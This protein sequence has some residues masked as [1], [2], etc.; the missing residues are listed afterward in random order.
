M[1]EINDTIKEEAIE[2]I[3]S[4]FASLSDSGKFNNVEFEQIQV[5]IAAGATKYSVNHT[6]AFRHARIIGIALNITDESVLEG[7]TMSMTIDSKEIF[8]EGTE[9]KLLFASTAVA[10]NQKFY[11]YVD[12]DINQST[13]NVTFTSNAF[14]S[15]YQA[16]FYLMCVNKL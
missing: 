11:T 13:V 7:T 5:N 15:A 2:L 3:K 16:N 9:A 10:P 1:G 8:P 6:T 4:A 14:A 12:R